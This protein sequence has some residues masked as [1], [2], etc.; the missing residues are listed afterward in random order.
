FPRQGLPT[1]VS[2]TS[3]HLVG[4]AEPKSLQSYA[5]IRSAVVLL[6]NTRTPVTLFKCE[7]KTMYDAFA[8][9]IQTTLLIVGALFPIVNPPENIP[10]FLALT[11]GLSSGDRSVL[12]RK[13]S[14][15][16][17]ALLIVSVLIGTHILAFFGISLPVVQVGG[18]LVVIATGWKLLNRAED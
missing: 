18:G 12:A 13:I 2:F 11:T 3:L 10:I 6:A 4:S 5:E 14:I 8:G 17:F 16:G 15:Y 1:A 7:A 9:L